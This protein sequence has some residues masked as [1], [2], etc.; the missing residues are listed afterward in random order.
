MYLLWSLVSVLVAMGDGEWGVCSQRAK[1]MDPNGRRP[2]RPLAQHHP[3]P[4]VH[5]PHSHHICMSACAR[6]VCVSLPVLLLVDGW[7]VIG[8]RDDVIDAQWPGERLI[9]AV[10]T[11][12][13]SDQ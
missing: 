7:L 13:A 4:S 8:A 1:R 5:C 2:S 10:Q 9:V 12:S 6:R 11:P 3:C